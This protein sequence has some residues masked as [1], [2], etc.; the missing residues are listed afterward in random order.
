MMFVSG[1]RKDDY[2]TDAAI[3]PLKEDLKFRTWRFE[4]NMVMSWLINTIDNEIGQNLMFYGTAKEIWDV[5][6]ETYSDNDNTTELLEIKSSLH[7]LRQGDLSATQY[8]NTLTR[9]WQ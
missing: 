5:A 9:F 6:K 3:P 8:I 2:L 1:K 4:N 7:D